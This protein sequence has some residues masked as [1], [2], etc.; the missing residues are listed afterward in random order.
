M[1]NLILTPLLVLL[2]SVGF[3]QSPDS[4]NFQ[5][6]LKDPKGALL[7]EQ[8]IGVRIGIYQGSEDGIKVFE[9]THTI[10][11]SATG[12]LYFLIGS[13]TNVS[14][15]IG[16]I[17]WSKGPYF[18]KREVDLA[19]G[20]DYTITGASQFYS[21]PYTKYADRTGNAL[22][23]SEVRVSTENDS[24]FIGKNSFVIIP[25]ITIANS[26]VDYDGNVY[27]TVTIGTQEWMAENLKVTHLN[28]G[29][30]IPFVYVS[31]DW[32]VRT[33]EPLRAYPN[34]TIPF[35][36]DSSGYYNNRDIYGAY[37]NWAAVNTGKLCPTGWHVPSRTEL[38]TLVDAMGGGD[39]AGTKAR[40][41][42]STYW[43]TSNGTDEYGFKARGSAYMADPGIIYVWIRDLF[44]LWTS[45]EKA[46]DE[47]YS[48]VITSYTSSFKEQA[49]TTFFKKHNGFSVRCLKD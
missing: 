43:K 27:P 36:E 9:E 10:T 1:K 31:A 44:I 47:A 2:I 30:E 22:D 39:Y 3:A 8:E 13:G 17:D 21:L 15:S 24:L 38:A 4:I 35:M 20:T 34:I 16:E 11:T 49:Q 33:A 48:R 28:D 5:G 41:T 19:G 7:K 6:V 23:I 40:E 25:G 29:T 46:S 14:G 12:Q 37:Y 26:V 42:G 32:P 18:L 45:T